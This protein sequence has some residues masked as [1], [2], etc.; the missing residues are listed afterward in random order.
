VRSSSVAEAFSALAPSYD[1][2]FDHNPI[3]RWMRERVWQRLEQVFRPGQHILDAGCGTGTD[4]VF[5]AQR[6]LRV[7]AVDISSEMI[8]VARRRQR[9]LSEGKVPGLAL[10][11]ASV[12]TPPFADATFD[13]ILCN[14]GVL[15]SVGDLGS[16]AARL[17]RVLKP[18]RPLIAAVMTNLCLGESLYFL[19]KGKWKAAFRRLNRNGTMAN[20]AG[21]W[22]MTY[23]YSPRSFA[24]SFASFF[25][26]QHIEALGAL[27]PPPYLA[28]FC[29]RHPRVWAVL[30]RL[31]QV[32]PACYPFYAIADHFL[33]E[34]VRR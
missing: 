34:M 23:Y 18:Q 19:A 26:I 28:P 7:T 9:A 4:A 20:V 8:A 15:N 10:G 5:L 14:F 21:R 29:R 13:G 6:G 30:Q 12:E 22:V 2:S 24:T 11:V 32:A 3:G 17:A 1:A 31:E 33:I 25:R 16:L 27:V